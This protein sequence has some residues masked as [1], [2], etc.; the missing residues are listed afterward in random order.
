MTYISIEYILMFQIDT[1]Y[2]RL[3]KQKQDIISK[4]R[5]VHH[6]QEQVLGALSYRWCPRHAGSPLCL[7]CE[8]CKL[9]ICSSC[10][11]SQHL[12]HKTV[13]LEQETHKV[14]D[15][16]NS[17]LFACKEQDEEISKRIA[18]LMHYK[19]DIENC[20]SEA[21]EQLTKRHEK[22]QQ[23]ELDVFNGQVSFLNQWKEE[24]LKPFDKE[25]SRLQHLNDHQQDVAH[26]GD[27]LLKQ[28]TSHEFISQSNTFLTC[29]RLA[30]LPPPPVM[31]LDRI[32]YHPPSNFRIQNCDFFRI[33]GYIA[34]E[35][36]TREVAVAV[37]RPRKG[38]IDSEYSVVADSG[39]TDVTN[40]TGMTNITNR[41]DISRVS[42]LPRTSRF[43]R[44]LQLSSTENLHRTTVELLNSTILNH[45]KVLI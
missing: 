31:P 8:Q 39:I 40:L 1:R 45:S 35:T 28:T 11:D 41:S 18:F 22:V 44:K 17:L 25:M 36:S 10:T 43:S 14:Q 42:R 23:A 3:Q 4:L 13:A 9:T 33:L 19:A 2:P 30:D 6:F 32:L 29:N 24:K 37:I 27:S 26:A 16:L 34:P 5:N 21:T 12:G 20:A 38:S 7:Y 15:G